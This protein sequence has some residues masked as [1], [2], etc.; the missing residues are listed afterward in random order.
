M[1][2]LM[3]YKTT[4][5]Q[6]QKVISS[7]TLDLVIWKDEKT[8]FELGREKNGSQIINYSYLKDNL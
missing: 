8:T 1:K 5:G 6:P 2:N 3:D 7:E 4:L